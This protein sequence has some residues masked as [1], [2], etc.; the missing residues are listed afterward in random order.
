M[1]ATSSRPSDAELSWE[2][3]LYR[4]NVRSIPGKSEY[5]DHAPGPIRRDTY[6]ISVNKRNDV[7]GP[8]AREQSYEESDCSWIGVNLM[9]LDDN[10]E[11]IEFAPLLVKPAST[12]WEA[13]CSNFE[14]TIRSW[15][16][17]ENGQHKD[18]EIATPAEYECVANCRSSYNRCWSFKLVDWHKTVSEVGLYFAPVSRAIC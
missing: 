18:V 8:K 17:P 9:N 13:L 5:V 2:T 12:I 1:G 3:D 16:R 14:S 7:S 11:N 4:Y 10:S 6:V 15:Q